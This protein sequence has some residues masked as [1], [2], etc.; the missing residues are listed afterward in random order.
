MDCDIYY[1]W[2][3]NTDSDNNV[4]C[5]EEIK[6]SL[7]SLI[8]GEINWFAIIYTCISIAII[9]LSAMYIIYSPT[10]KL[11]GFIGVGV[12]I[13]MMIVYYFFSSVLGFIRQSW[14]N[15]TGRLVMMLILFITLLIIYKTK[16]R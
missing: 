11:Y 1:P 3:S 14:N 5:K 12:G 13:G 4:I 15:Q 8:I 6:M 10:Y 7:L 9:L 2:R 16:K